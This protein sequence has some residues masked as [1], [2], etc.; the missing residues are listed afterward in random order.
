MA[1]YGAVIVAAGRGSRMGGIDKM[2][3]LLGGWPLFCHALAAF[4]AC[5]LIDTIVL[6][7]AAERVEEAEIAVQK[8]GF[9]KLAAICSGG[10]RRQDSVRA[11]LEQLGRLEV[12]AIHDAARPLVSPALI[13]AGFA[14][15]TETGAA[16]AAIP[17]VDTIKEVDG[18][19]TVIRTVSREQLWAVQT[20][21]VFNFELLLEAHL[22]SP[23]DVTDD[24]MLVEAYGH[25]VKVFLGSPRNLKVTT[26][27]D[28]VLAEALLGL[29]AL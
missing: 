9:S 13:A 27:D 28:L 17:V 29:L 5:S 16:I 21:Q 7:T 18:D 3:A 2:F 4:E 12:V 25:R 8:F 24:A 1:R 11:G 15:A 6:V 23:G 20:P 14:A 19:G 10:G 26:P 22:R